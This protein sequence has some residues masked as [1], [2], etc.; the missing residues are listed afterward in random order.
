MKTSRMPRIDIQH[1]EIRAH[2]YI[3]IYIYN[4]TFILYIQTHTH[5]H[6]H[7]HTY[8]HLHT[9]IHHT[10]IPAFSC[11]H[12]C[13]STFTHTTYELIHIHTCT[14]ALHSIAI[15]MIRF[16]FSSSHS[17]SPAV[18]SQC[19]VTP[20]SRYLLTVDANQRNFNVIKIRD[21]RSERTHSG[22]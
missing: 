6:T 11:I 20:N 1:T 7:M 22:E 10:Y 18:C 5:I 15:T 19:M 9:C 12:A 14:H 2:A 13:I 8:I 4:Y 16:P 3:R 21:T 17:R